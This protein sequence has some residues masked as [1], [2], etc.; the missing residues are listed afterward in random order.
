MSRWLPLESNPDA[1]NLFVSKL[2]V[3]V[4]SGF[5]FCDVF[6]LD[7]GLLSM[8]PQP[9]LAVMLL[10]PND[11]ASE[12]H[13]AEQKAKIVASGK[14]TNPNVW[15]MKQTIGNACGTVGLIHAIANNLDKLNLKE[16]SFL[17]GYFK[18]SKALSEEE[19]CGKLDEGDGIAT[20]HEE[21]ATADSETKAP[22]LMDDIKT[23]FICFTQ[24][25]GEL[26]E[27]DGRKHAPISHGATTDA[28]F[29]SDAAAICKQFMDRNPGSMEFSLTALAGN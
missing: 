11:Q 25:D 22:D 9:C 24:V 28:T 29:L 5:T 19:R 14:P 26:Y 17:D 12:A 4:S 13:A 2:G 16:G 15:F 21:A 18:D 23:H 6:G 1:F 10:F 8:V 3:E 7:P 20:A 27:L